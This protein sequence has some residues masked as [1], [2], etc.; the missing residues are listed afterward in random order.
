MTPVVAWLYSIIAAVAPPDKEHRHPSFPGWEET[1]EERVERY[2]SI[3]SDVVAV[4][5]DPEKKPLFGGALGR[6][7]T[8][9]LLLAV[10][11]HESG[12]AKDV[13]KGPCYRGKGGRS[14]RCDHGKSA[15]LMQIRIGQ[16]TTQEGWTQDELFADR[17][18]CFSAGLNLMRKSISACR[19]LDERHRLNAYASGVCERGH[20]GSEGLMSLMHDFLT[21]SPIPREAR[22]GASAT[23][24][25]DKPSADKPSGDKEESKKSPPPK[26]RPEPTS[27]A[28]KPATPPAAKKK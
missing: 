25:D 2:E 6:A 16:G 5:F 14:A 23:P 15:C 7:R 11:Y 4:A 27:R 10:A 24:G 19:N 17:K 28:R 13:D 18:K 20:R 22:A 8:A 9:A 12:F 1:A 26:A 3:A 21:K